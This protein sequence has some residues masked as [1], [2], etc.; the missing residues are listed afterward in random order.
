LP[1]SRPRTSQANGK[2]KRPSSN[3]SYYSPLRQSQV[4]AE[5]PAE[6]ARALDQNPNTVLCKQA[7]YKYGKYFMN[8]SSE[9]RQSKM[10]HDILKLQRLLMRDQ[11]KSHH[12]LFKFFMQ[13]GYTED[14]VK[15]LDEVSLSNLIT[16]VL[17]FEELPASV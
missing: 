17:M 8:K 16:E 4:K 1:A 15:T 12:H 14:Q 7:Y 2:S 10:A 3:I 11:A 9:A 5:N 13:A 6:I